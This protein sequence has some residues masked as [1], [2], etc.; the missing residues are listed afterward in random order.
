MKKHKVKKPQARE[1]IISMIFRPLVFL[2]FICLSLN[3]SAKDKVN[4]I[5]K[6]TVSTNQKDIALKDAIE[7]IEKQTGYLFIYN[8][9]IDLNTKISL[10]IND[11]PIEESINKM[12]YKTNITYAIKDKNILL[13][14]SEKQAKKQA[15]IA[16]KGVVTD[17]RDEPLVGVQIA[18]KDGSTGVISNIDGQFTL[19]ANP[20]DILIVSYIG[21]VTREININ[22][23]KDFSIILKEDIKALD[24]VIVVGYGTTSTRKMASAVTALKGEKL[25]NLPYNDINSALQGRAAG[26]IVQNSGGAPGSVPSISIRGGGNPVY[27][28]DGIVSSAWDFNTLNAID[29]ENI[30][31]LKDAASLAV[32]GSR[33]ADGIIMIQTKKGG[34]GKTTVT[35]NFNADYNQPTKRN[36]KVNSYTYARLQNEAAVNDGL[37]PFSLYDEETLEI[38]RNGSQPYKYG[39]DNWVGL[40]L[41]S[42][43]PQ[44]KHSVALN[45]SSKIVD[46]YLSLGYLDQGSLLKS[47]ALNYKRYNIRSSV[48]TTFEEIGLKLGLNINAA[49]EKKKSPSFGYGE[50]YQHIYGMNPLTPAFNEDGTYSAASDHPLVEM[51]KRSGYSNNNGNF[52]NIQLIADWSIPKIDGLVLGAMLHYRINNSHDKSFRTKAPQYYPDGNIFPIAKPTLNEAAYFGESYNFD[53]SATYIKEILDGHNFEAKMVFTGTQSKG[54]NFSAWR[55]DYISSAVDQL[56]AGS[57]EGLG[58]TGNG[59]ESGRMGLVGRV[60]Y[61]YKGRYIAEGSFRYDGSDNF[62]KSKRWGLFPS[63]AI[64]WALSEESF[65]KSLSWDFVNLIKVRASYGKT[66]T[67]AGVNR[68]GYLPVYNLNTN[69]INIGGKLVSG[70]SEGPLVAPMELT[71]YTRNSL[72]Y[73]LDFTL[74]DYRL[75]GALDYFYYV[76]KGG[77]M[78]PTDRYITPLGTSLPQIKSNSVHRREGVELALSWSDKI[79]SEFS[80]DI[81]FNMTYFDSLWKRKADEDLNS[82]M[83]PYKRTTNE[84][85]FYGNRYHSTGIYQRLEDILNSPRRPQSTE[86][87]LGDIGYQDFNGDGK[88]D[89]EDQTRVGSS[90]MPHITYGFD[91]ALNYKGFT[92]S[93]LF[94][95]TGK[96]NLE[97]STIYKYGLSPQLRYPQQ[98]DF[99]TVDNTTARFPRISSI[100]KVNGQN[101]EVGSTF[102]MLDAKF[103]RLKNLI[104]SYDFKYKLLKNTSW[105]NKLA[106]SLKATNL[107]TISKVNK[108]FDPE[109]ASVDGA[110][111]PVQR[112]YSIGLTLGF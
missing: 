67:E 30:S 50:I 44:Y 72:N 69:V 7:I 38:I 63:A 32:Y 52:T 3:A 99:W 58:N 83:N 110:G 23:K 90:T 89:S 29:I 10:E 100:P 87:K 62:T 8:E 9:S 96:R 12:L 14:K 76:T 11:K 101:N 26:V 41:K 74:F 109:T 48:S 75:T 37:E 16:I 108:F 56:F 78:S 106:F 91:F 88:I 93:G 66:G 73:G 103:L 81:G 40:G 46:Y 24:E 5:Q 20:T 70:F 25:D 31:I 86:T 36:K 53:L 105:V 82:L 45:G 77:L 60:K 4:N 59:D 98:L 19:Q 64:A 22:N 71:W 51:D 6:A 17:E 2:L 94:Y 13:F 104:F 34:K 111:Y 35:Y 80:Y 18:I 28:I 61:D 112:T 92:L 33:A 102:W 68:F 47:D 97:F 15:K 65:F 95:G 27:V 42:I 107:F 55:K 85:S 49:V 57:Q 79:G 39:V 84:K 21:Y 1:N 54:S 43:A